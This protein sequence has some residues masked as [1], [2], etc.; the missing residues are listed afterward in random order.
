M[1]RIR[2]KSSYKIGIQIS[3]YLIWYGLGRFVIEGLRSDSLY[4]GEFKV[5]QIVS[6]AI[7]VIGLVGMIIVRSKNR[8][9]YTEIGGQDGR[10]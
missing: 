9:K 10:I 6:L 1:W 5:S 7:V 2:R 4:L 8:I 3:F